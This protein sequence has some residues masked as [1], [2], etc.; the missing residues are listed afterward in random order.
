VIRVTWN[1][2]KSHLSS[3]ASTSGRSDPA[4][5]S[6]R[7]AVQDVMHSFYSMGRVTYVSPSEQNVWPSMG[8]IRRRC[9]G[10]G[11]WF[12]RR[13]ILQSQGTPHLRL[14]GIGRGSLLAEIKAGRNTDDLTMQSLIAVGQHEV[15]VG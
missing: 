1:L 9:C 6:D 13:S 14:I 12:R 2:L 3:T 8:A 10:A 5:D 4:D 15:T 7:S 11:L